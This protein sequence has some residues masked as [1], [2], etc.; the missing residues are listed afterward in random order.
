MNDEFYAVVK[1]VT[2]EEVLGLVESFDD[3]ILIKDPLLLEDFSMIEEMFETISA[4]GIKLIKW[5]KS[6]SDDMFYIF[7]PQIVT[8]GELKEPV[9]SLYKKSLKN[10]IHK[11][12]SNKQSISKNKKNYSGYKSTIKE[13]RSKFEKLFKDY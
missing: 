9:L 5:I 12:V 4:R 7:Q 8:I 6:S 2:G 3:G 13:A 11:N 1:L 10:L